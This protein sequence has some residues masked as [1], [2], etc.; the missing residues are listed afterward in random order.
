MAFLRFSLCTCWVIAALG[1]AGAMAPNPPA[2]TPNATGVGSRQAQVTAEQLFERGQALAAI[3]EYEAAE[4]T[5]VQALTAGLSPAR[6]L[7]VLLDSCGAI[8]RRRSASDVHAADRSEGPDV[9][10]AGVAYATPYLRLHPDDFQVRYRV[11]A[12]QLEL[13]NHEE[14]RQDLQRVLEAAPNFAPAHYLMGIT[15]RDH[16]GDPA[17]AARH[18]S[19]YQRLIT[20]GNATRGTDFWSML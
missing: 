7:P 2:T 3:G 14:A 5:L 6:V 4:A 19:A 12:L 13:G 1:C 10:R 9:L 8:A 15:L 11:A 18:F 20:H 16:F 17:Q